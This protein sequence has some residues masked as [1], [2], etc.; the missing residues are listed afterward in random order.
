MSTTAKAAAAGLTAAVA[1]AGFELLKQ[2][3]QAIEA[4]QTL[5]IAAQSMHALTGMSTQDALA[6]SIATNAYGVNARAMSMS[7][8]LLATQPV[9]AEGGS[10]ASIQTF[11]WMG[12]SMGDLK[13]EHRQSPS[14]QTHATCVPSTT[15]PG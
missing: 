3:K 2:G 1:V 14:G 7:L 4:S 13:R 9:N 11:T 5:M 10:K 6:W 15:P 12:I 8:K